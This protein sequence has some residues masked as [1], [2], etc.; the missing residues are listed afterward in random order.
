MKSKFGN[1]ATLDALAEQW[2]VQGGTFNLRVWTDGSP[3]KAKIHHCLMLEKVVD[4]IDELEKPHLKLVVMHDFM[5]ALDEEQASD[6]AHQHQ[7]RNQDSGHNIWVVESEA[8]DI[9]QNIISHALWPGQP[10]VCEY[11]KGQSLMANVLWEVA[12]RVCKEVL[13]L[14]SLED[15]NA[16]EV[17]LMELKNDILTMWESRGRCRTSSLRPIFT[18]SSAGASDKRSTLGDTFT[19]S[20][21]MAYASTLHGS[22]HGLGEMSPSLSRPLGPPP[23]IP[24][25]LMPVSYEQRIFPTLT[26][27]AMGSAMGYNFDPMMGQPLWPL[28]SS[29]YP[30]LSQSPGMPFPTSISLNV[31]G[32][33]PLPDLG[34]EE[35]PLV[36]EPPSHPSWVVAGGMIPTIMV[37]SSAVE[38]TVSLA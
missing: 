9:S 37:S 29:T 24:Y 12:Y 7:V 36:V 1:Y 32:L 15:F 10:M 20:K 22:S 11:I 4:R 14:D 13:H 6:R 19:P 34:K 38:T 5:W 25:A 16:T 23:G 26:C 30:F 28:V 27:S 2:R 17:D 8:H 31:A 18:P 3:S 33:P 21:T 35:C